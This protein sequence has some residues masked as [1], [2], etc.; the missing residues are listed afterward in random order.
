M[1]CII[2]SY[3]TGAPKWGIKIHGILQKSKSGENL[4]IC[5]FC[6]ISGRYFVIKYEQTARYLYARLLKWGEIQ[7]NI[8]APLTDSDS[9]APQIIA[10]RYEF[11]VVAATT[12]EK[13]LTEIRRKELNFLISRSCP[14]NFSFLRSDH[15]THVILSCKSAEL[16]SP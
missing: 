9:L 6:I 8:V 13:L 4:M 3:L 7:E 5:K 1:L 10:V 15:F 12:H 11:A 16:F 2:Y 14:I